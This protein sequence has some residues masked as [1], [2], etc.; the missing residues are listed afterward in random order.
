MEYLIDPEEV[1]TVG[2][3]PK[4][5]PCTT[6]CRI[7]PMYGVPI[8]E[9]QDFLIEIIPLLPYSLGGEEDPVGCFYYLS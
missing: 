4:Y 8:I 3:C 7:K 9:V 2:A 6:F 5:N 1:T